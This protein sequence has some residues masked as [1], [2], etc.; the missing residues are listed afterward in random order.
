MFMLR[1]VSKFIFG[2][3]SKESII[4]IPQGQLYLVR[5]L[6]PKGYSELIFKDAAA[7]IRRTGQEFQYQL[8]IQRAYEEG[9]EELGEDEDGEG[10]ADS[11]DKD[12]KAFLLDQNLHF[13]SEVREGSSKILAWRDLSGD[14]GDLFEFVCDPSV[15][16]DKV[17]TF[18]LA[19]LQCQYERKYRRSAQRATQEELQE[20]SFQEEKPIPTAS[21]IA[22]PA[23]SRAHS[24]ASGD[25]TMVRDTAYTR[26]KRQLAA[27]AATEAPTVAP[28][29]AAHPEARETLTQEKAELHL[30]DLPSGTFVLQDANVVATVTEVGDWQ[31]WLQIS[32]DN[33]DW[34]GQAVVADINPVFNFEYLS[35]IFNHYDE[36]GSAYSWLLRFKDQ[37]TEERFQQ[38]LLQALWE[39]LNEAKW[40]K[41][42]DNDKDYVLDAFQELT[43]ED[44]DQAA[45]AEEEEEEEEEEDKYDGQRSEHYDSDEEQDDVVTRDDDGNINSQLAVGY[46]HDRSFV[47]RGSKI[48]VFKHTPDN[49]LEF[50]TNISKV[51]T[52]KGKLFSPKKVMLHAEDSNMILQNSDNP[53]SLYR[54]DLEY[55]KI[56]DEWKVHDDIPVHTFAP[57]SKFSQMTSAQPFVGAS[58]NALFRVD[59]RVSGNKLVEAELK[60]YASKNDFSALATTEKGYLA[61]ASNKGDIRMFDRLGINAKTHI[62]A[63]GEAIIGLD[64]S[65][66]GRWVLATCRTYLLLIDSMQK[67]GKNEGKLGFERSFAKDS[68]PQPRRLGLQPAHVAQFQHETKKPI[69]FTPARFNTGV[70]S[71]ETSIVTAT[72]PFIIT[73]SLKKVTSG[74]KDPYTIKRYSEEVMADNFRFGS[75]KNVIVALPN[76]VNM[77][78][79]RA[80]QKPTRES[81]AGPVT[82]SRRSTRWG[83]RLGR[84]DIVNSPY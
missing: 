3:S 41:V 10:V 2:D 50:S 6:S 54:M 39:Q 22:S 59:P 79:K 26:A 67:E 64:V 65:A 25:S 46:K 16:S 78:A 36:N 23:K 30:F 17:S 20:F 9:E 42:K 84:D 43:M 60:Q 7:S 80:L 56:V 83:S 82:P 63:L 66:N 58:H 49:N 15:P 57:E 75:D 70:D 69:S 52:P 19:A 8:V 14:V 77:V 21:P 4:D 38:G 74:R 71:Q 72:G 48:G 61:V 73:W 29:S 27:P 55:G 44:A 81:I 24:L 34:L 11:L 45:E 18:E 1:N 12:E 35:F 68:K 33:R 5:P 37:D 62:P 32:G 47:V 53:N 76:E 31:Y 28:P 40:T 51:E 13:R